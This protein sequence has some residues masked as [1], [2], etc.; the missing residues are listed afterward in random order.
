[1]LYTSFKREAMVELVFV[2]DMFEL[3]PWLIIG[4]GF[5]GG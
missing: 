1:L 5:E 3:N 4:V 2:T